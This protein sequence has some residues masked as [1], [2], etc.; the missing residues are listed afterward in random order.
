[1]TGTSSSVMNVATL[2]HQSAHNTSFVGHLN[3]FVTHAP[4]FE[5]L[6]ETPFSEEVGFIQSKLLTSTFP[7]CDTAATLARAQKLHGQPPGVSNGLA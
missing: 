1:M 6:R 7:A 2:S 5:L 3:G 4:N